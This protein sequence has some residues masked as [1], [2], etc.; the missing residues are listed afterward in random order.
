MYT[1]KSKKITFCITLLQNVLLFINVTVI[2]FMFS[3]NYIKFEYF[4]IFFIIHLINYLVKEIR[5]HFDLLSVFIFF[6]LIFYFI[7]VAIN[8]MFIMTNNHLFQVLHYEHVATKANKIFVHEN[9][10]IS[11]YLIFF[12]YLYLISMPSLL[13]Y[14]SLVFVYCF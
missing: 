12:Y 14:Y 2:L 4:L 9:S 1:Y 8:F 10:N 11:R 3:K 13:F 5:V 7:T 6:I